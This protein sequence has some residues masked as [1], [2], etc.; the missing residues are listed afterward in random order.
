M[1]ETRNLVTYCF[2]MNR[3][4]GRIV[5]V[6]ELVFILGCLSA[7][8]AEAQVTKRSVVAV[9]NVD[10]TFL[11]SYGSCTL[12]SYAIVANYF[13]RRPVTDFFEGY[14]HKYA[15]FYVTPLQAEGRYADHFEGEYQRRQCRGIE[16]ILDL[17]SNSTEKCFVEAR[18]LFDA[19]FYL[20]SNDHLEELETALK[21]KEAFVNLGYATRNDVHTVTVFYDGT[22][23][24][25]R[26]TNLKGFYS[27]TRLKEIGRLA[28]GVL[29]VKK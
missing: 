10:A 4:L 14:C 20:D 6:A 28:D 17:H 9:T 29:Y 5:P 23:F 12:S 2:Y 16:V 3:G 11:Q 7:W 13:T 15:I 22:R 21:T 19:H 18:R 24:R 26:D 1:F 27:V 25:V 8:A